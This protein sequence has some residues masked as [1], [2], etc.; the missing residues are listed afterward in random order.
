[1][2][3][4]IP[5]DQPCVSGSP[6]LLPWGARI[7]YLIAWFAGF[8]FLSLPINRVEAA[9]AGKNNR[10]AQEKRDDKRVRDSKASLDAA[11]REL[12]ESRQ[13]LTSADKR[14]KEADRR[15][16]AAGRSV[17]D[18]K[19]KAEERLEKQ[20]GLEKMRATLRS[21]TETYEKSVAPIREKIHSLPDYRAATEAAKDAQERI[22]ALRVETSLS[23]AEHAAA[24][25]D[26]YKIAR[27]PKEIEET[28]L[29]ADPVAQEAQ[30]RLDQ[31]RD[32]A[33]KLRESVRERI[34]Q[35]SDV[36][37]AINE[38]HAAKKDE[39]NAK[40]ALETARRAVARHQQEVAARKR[41]VSQAKAADM[42]NDVPRKK[43]KGK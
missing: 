9:Q 39:D 13:K 3:R 19:E 42:K 7:G 6:R 12:H 15:H 33:A 5:F 22:E 32:E 30:A 17:S 29:R 35:E 28:A 27:K 16:E 20:L 8:L 14:W 37:K 25:T 1:M 24:V 23:D 4:Q 31:V 34:E 43:P 40:S 26:A 10:N 41:G 2:K 36:R 21:A 11:E 38:L 18:A